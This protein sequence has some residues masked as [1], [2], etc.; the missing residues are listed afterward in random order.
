MGTSY[1]II[2]AREELDDDDDDDDGEELDWGRGKTRV[3]LFS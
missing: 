1:I 2:L 3:F